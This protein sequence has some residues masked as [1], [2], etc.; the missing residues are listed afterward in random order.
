MSDLNIVPILPYMLCTANMPIFMPS[1][2][3]SR[4]HLMFPNWIGEYGILGCTIY[5]LWSPKCYT[6]TS[7]SLRLLS[8]LGW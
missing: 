4:E 8:R 1:Y 7:I 3:V 6:K 2:L 5:W